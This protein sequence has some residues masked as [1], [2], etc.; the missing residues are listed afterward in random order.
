MPSQR[1]GRAVRGSGAVIED[2][3]AAVSAAVTAGMGV[4]GFGRTLARVAWAL[5]VLLALTLFLAAVPALYLQYSE[6]PEDVRASLA[7]LGLSG[8]VYAAFR[9]LTAALF[10]LLCFA[11]AALVVRH[12]MDDGLRLFISLFLVLLGATGSPNAGA[13]VWRYP[14]LAPAVQVGFVLDVGALVVFLFVFPDGQFVP[15]RLRLPVWILTMGLLLTLLIT[16]STLSGPSSS[17]AASA[18]FLL[19]VGLLGLGV[20]SQVYR[21]SRIAGPIQRQ[22]IKWVLLGTAAA[23]LAPLP[24]VLPTA[25]VPALQPPSRAAAVLELIRTAATTIWF[26]I[27]LSIAFAVL[28]YRLWDV[29]VLINRALVYGALT[30]AVIGL[31]VLVVGGLGAVFQARG[32]PLISFLAT[33]VV[34]VCFQPL[35]ARL[36]RAANRLLYGD[37]DEPYAVLSRLG[38]RLETTLAPDAV[39]PTIVHTVREALKL[40]YVAVSVRRDGAPLETVAAGVEVGAAVHLPLVY[41]HEQV[42]ELILA[43]RA[44][45]AGFS[46][47]DRRLLDDLARQAGVAVHAIRLTS[48]VQHA[49]ERLVAA[50]EEER[51]RLRRDLHDGLGPQLASQTLTLDV[52]Y[53]LLHQDPA[54]VEAL[55]ITLRQQTQAAVADIRRLVYDLRPPALDDLGLVAAV[56]QQASSYEQGGLKVSVTGP[57]R[58]PGL[59]AAVEVATYRIVQEALTN[60]VRHAQART[61]SVRLTFDGE[62]LCLEV[63]DDGQGLPAD[64]L[65]GVGLASMRERATELGGWCRI[66]P[67]PTGGTRV[68]AELPCPHAAAE[69]SNGAPSPSE[70]QVGS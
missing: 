26:L 60:V 63:T 34:A 54:A 37:R 29:D 19:M 51:R 64:R 11:V 40:P 39:L 67:I 68:L 12:K 53:R 13:V 69:T 32:D 42:G 15:R 57:E 23:L 62:R 20:G 6:P 4:P 17:W 1:K 3:V 48:E 35:R 36:Q 47:A 58:L 21:Y 41:Q 52:A 16:G 50:R 14:E 10:G 61:C 31:Y 70:R 38:Q 24:L 59:P 5:A 45:D 18:P 33:G 55:L 7:D 44:A 43:P 2:R 27:P 65:A 8:S 49:R 56:R 30:A 66:E 28:R 46:P 9:T 25:F 22:Q